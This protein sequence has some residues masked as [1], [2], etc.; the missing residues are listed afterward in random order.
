[1]T[2]GSRS[3]R[4]L[5]EHSLQEHTPTKGHT[6]MADATGTLVADTW[7][8]GWTLPPTLTVWDLIWGRW[9]G[10]SRQLRICCGETHLLSS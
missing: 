9:A 4:Y 8:K 6:L 2:G 10:S 5:Q 3:E 1:M 7:Q